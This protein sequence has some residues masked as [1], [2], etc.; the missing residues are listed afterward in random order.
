MDMDM[1]QFKLIVCVIAGLLFCLECGYLIYHFLE[2]RQSARRIFRR[3]GSEEETVFHQEDLA[4][5]KK[6]AGTFGDFQID[7]I[8][9]NDL[10]MDCIYAKMNASMSSAGDIGL[11][12]ILR[13]P[14]L[15]IEE[16]KR[17]YAIIDWFLQHEEERNKIRSAVFKIRFQGNVSLL[18]FYD[19]KR[20]G[21]SLFFAYGTLCIT[22]LGLLSAV[23]FPASF[24]FVV[25]MCITNYTISYTNRIKMDEVY[26]HILQLYRYIQALHALDQL[27]LDTVFTSYQIH[28][29]A[30]KLKAV[31]HSLFDDFHTGDSGIFYVI[32]H[33][34]YGEIISYH[35]LQKKMKNHKQDVKQVILLMQDIDAFLSAAS[36]F[37]LQPIVCAAQ[38]QTDVAI[39]AKEMVHP[40]LQQ[41]VANDVEIHS[42]ILISGSNASGKS[43][44][45][46]MLAINA[47]F[48]QSFGYAFAKQY[49]ACPFHIYTSMSLKDSLQ[50][51][52]SYFVA[53]VRS[54]QRILKHLSKQQPVLCMID[55]ILRGTNTIERIAAASEILMSF[56]HTPSLCIS[57]THDI[58]LTHILSKYYRNMHF[59]EQV[60]K[61]QLSFDY[62]L[63]EGASHTHNALA[64]LELY[65]YDTSIVKEA[66]ALQ[67]QYEQTG[68][69]QSI[70]KEGTAYGV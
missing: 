64:L 47:I 53:E 38:F 10:D 43:T 68:R 42:H 36:F 13:C 24:L 35:R 58:E 30:M 63:Y 11:Y 4:F 46:K 12:R 57:A 8:T 65:G 6:E 17:R 23:V 52:D 49:L 27:H 62:H 70:Q 66:K 9:W 31:Q 2:K 26:D 40:L 50:E 61:E 48:A 16:S 44:Y 3:W 21:V 56:V 45:L 29:L 54:I 59:Q 55:E 69:W 32:A 22:L 20:Q 51:K 15:S 41:P 5:I 25:L 37:S 33:F 7:D 67:K 14:C 60:E 18:S 28:P 39:Q 19:K 1:E 34:F